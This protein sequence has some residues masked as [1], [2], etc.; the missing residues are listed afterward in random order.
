MNHDV[1]IIIL[2]HKSKNLVIEYIKNIYGKFKIIIID[3]SKDFE[4]QKIIKE[5]FPYVTIHLI[6]NNGYG[7]G[8]NFGSKLVNTKYFLISNPDVKSI[9]E[10]NIISFINA[11]KYLKDKFTALGPRYLDSDPRSL[12]QSNQDI[13]IAEMRFLSGACMFFNKKNFNLLG[14]FDENIFLYF[15]E[16]DL[17]KRSTK[18]AKNYQ[19]NN[20]KV[21]HDAGNSVTLKNDSEIEDQREFR[22]W[23]FVWSKFYYFKKNYGFFLALLFFIPIILRTGIKILYYQIKKDEIN[24]FK[25]KNRWSG[26]MSSIRGEKSYKRPKF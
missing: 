5:N 26:I 22:S 17:C 20:I 19:I 7:Q 15:D 3:N 10:N 23:H 6:D 1:T 13:D 24:L 14:G 2:T 25:Y 9:N 4:L 11:A 16:N 12:K 21:Y 8:I 18:F